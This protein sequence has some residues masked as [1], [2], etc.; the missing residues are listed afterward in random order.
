[1]SLLKNEQLTVIIAFIQV[2][3][4][5]Q[6][7]LQVEYLIGPAH[8][9][10]LRHRRE[11]S[12]P[13]A[14]FTPAENKLSGT[15]AK[16]GNFPKYKVALQNETPVNLGTMENTRNG[17]NMQQIVLYR[18]TNT[19][20]TTS[21][22][23]A[24]VVIIP[25]LIILITITLIGIFIFWR[26]KRKQKFKHSSNGLNI[27]RNNLSNE[28]NTL[29]RVSVMSASK[30]QQKVNTSSHDDDFDFMKMNSPALNK[31]CNII[32]AKEVNVLAKENIDVDKG[33]EV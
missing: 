16:S 33:T 6:W 9:Q 15:N 7:Y 21:D 11:V 23:N 19:S 24:I 1:M 2:D 5:H 22:F 26:R 20:R 28:K 3:S 14:A 32:K 27:Q 10:I 4:G 18:P 17:T 30:A 8:S 31:P 25:I 13:R 12:N 29:T